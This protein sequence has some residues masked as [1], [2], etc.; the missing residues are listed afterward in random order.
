MPSA[1]GWIFF[2]YR[3]TDKET[4]LTPASKIK[5][6]C[7][8]LGGGGGGVGKQPKVF[9]CMFTRRV[10]DWGSATHRSSLVLCTA[11]RRTSRNWYAHIQRYG[12]IIPCC[13]SVIRLVLFRGKIHH[14]VYIRTIPRILVTSFFRDIFCLVVINY[15]IYRYHS[16]HA[17]PHYVYKYIIVSRDTL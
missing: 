9:F 4:R 12:V 16:C 2:C 7:L 6:I 15:K 8:G 13:R 14:Y 3:T 5:S 1:C 11:S 10:D 17:R